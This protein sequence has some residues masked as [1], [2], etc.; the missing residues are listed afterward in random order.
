MEEG[1]PSCAQVLFKV[2]RPLLHN[3]RLNVSRCRVGAGVFHSMGRL[4]ATN[5]RLRRLAIL[6]NPSWGS[7][8][9]GRRLRC[10]RVAR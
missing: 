6:V 2:G 7:Q 10:N 1:P 8:G 9:A 5:P 3:T 4:V